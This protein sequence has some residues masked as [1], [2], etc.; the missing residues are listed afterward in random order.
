MAYR[1]GS[2]CGCGGLPCAPASCWSAQGGGGGLWEACGGCGLWRG[3]GDLREDSLAAARGR[4]P[5]APRAQVLR[6]HGALSL[7]WCSGPTTLK[8]CPRPQHADLPCLAPVSAKC[9]LLP[10]GHT[11][12]V[13]CSLD[14]GW[15]WS[16]ALYV[17]ACSGQSPMLHL[18]Q[19]YVVGI[20]CVVSCWQPTKPEVCPLTEELHCLADVLQGGACGVPPGWGGGRHRALELPLPQRFQSPDRCPLC[21]QRS[22]HQGAARCFRNFQKTGRFGSLWCSPPGLKSTQK[23]M[24][25]NLNSS[26]KQSWPV[27]VLVFMVEFA[28]CQVSEHASWSSLYYGRIISAALEAVGEACCLFCCTVQVRCCSAPVSGVHTP[29]P[30]C[31]LCLLPLL[32]NTVRW[33]SAPV[34]GECKVQ[35]SAEWFQCTC[36]PVQA[37][38][39]TWSR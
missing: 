32:L 25:W 3:D 6:D 11:E 38:P 26:L 5:P 7:P 10:N 23:R 2:S 16:V 24:S 21:G 18:A 13:A 22:G 17:L 27:P 35:I 31:V 39:R 28:C 14:G 12:P 37:R 34:S 15:T 1:K 30:V 8:I 20:A 29:V 33:C 4:A 36:M 9:T 19:Q